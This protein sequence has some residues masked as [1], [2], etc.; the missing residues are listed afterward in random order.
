MEKSEI[1]RYTTALIGLVDILGWQKWFGAAV[2]GFAFALKTNN[3]FSF[4]QFQGLVIGVSLI[5]C[6]I[7]AVNDCFDV[8]IDKIKKEIMGKELIVS[9]IISR[10][11]ALIITCLALLIGVF[12]AAIASSSFFGIVLLM[13]LV[14]FVITFTAFQR[15]R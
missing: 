7:Q 15:V 6:Y 4:I 12:S 8:E 5:L 10:K 13:A 14:L 2:L 9:N 3:D 1:F 11:T